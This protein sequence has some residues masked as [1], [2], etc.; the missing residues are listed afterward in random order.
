MAFPHNQMNGGGKPPLA[1]TR[2]NNGTLAQNDAS[3]T[4]CARTCGPAGVRQ[5]EWQECQRVSQETPHP[6]GARSAGKS[7]TLKLPAHHPTLPIVT[8]RPKTT[9]LVRA[10]RRAGCPKGSAKLAV[11]VTNSVAQSVSAMARTSL[12]NITL[13]QLYPQPCLSGA[14]RKSQVHRYCVFGHLWSFQ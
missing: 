5:G 1:A 10:A 4:P 3:R 13:K 14:A 12:V 11:I 6:Q 8:R 9:G 2:H 7:A